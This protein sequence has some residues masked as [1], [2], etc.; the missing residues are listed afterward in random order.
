M[1][2]FSAYSFNTPMSSRK[3]SRADKK[4]KAD[5]QKDP[6]REKE[7][8]FYW[9]L[10]EVRKVSSLINDDKSIEVLYRSVKLS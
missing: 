7:S 4:E 3:S 5:M 10:S 1:L 2:R 8:P 9:V 6:I